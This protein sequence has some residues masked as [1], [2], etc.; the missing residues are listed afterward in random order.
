M[1]LGIGGFGKVRLMVDLN[2]R[3]IWAIKSYLKE[4]YLLNIINITKQIINI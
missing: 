2:N 1:L 3:K 4:R